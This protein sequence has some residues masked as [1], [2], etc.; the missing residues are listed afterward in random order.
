MKRLVEWYK[1]G[2]CNVGVALFKTTTDNG[3]KI[4]TGYLSTAGCT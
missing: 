4:L 2:D 3:L 1:N